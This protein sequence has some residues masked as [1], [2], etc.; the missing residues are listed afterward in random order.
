MSDAEESLE[1][2]LCRLIE[3]LESGEPDSEPE[4]P[5]EGAAEEA[6]PLRRRRDPPKSPAPDPTPTPPP[7]WRRPTAVTAALV[8]VAFAAGRGG[9]PSPAGGQGAPPARPTF[10]YPPPED[11]T[12]RRMTFEDFLE[13]AARA[14]P[15]P[16]RPR[17]TAVLPADDDRHAIQVFF[18]R[19][20]ETLTGR[21]T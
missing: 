8:V 11:V 6:A 10:E 5:A 16:A 19:I 7:G 14:E 18:D 1:A 21:Q 15:R 4:D 17:R 20:F 13:E 3:R 12:L 2:D 9:T